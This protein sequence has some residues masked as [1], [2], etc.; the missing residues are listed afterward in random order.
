[1]SLWLKLVEIIPKRGKKYKNLTEFISVK[2]FWLCNQ[3]LLT[4]NQ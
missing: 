1:M 2:H 4:E 3:S